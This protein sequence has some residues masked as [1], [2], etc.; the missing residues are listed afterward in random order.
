LTKDA[1]GEA[2][3]GPLRLQFDRFVKLAFRGSSISSDGGLLLH[4]ELDDAL[5][6]T[7]TAAGLIGDPRV[8]KNGRHRLTKL[9]RQSIFSR[10]AGYEGVNDA[11]RL[12]RDPLM[13]QLV[14]GRAVK[15]GAAS[16]SAM[17]RFETA[18]LTRPENLA[19]LA[20]LRGRWID[21][22]HDR[23]PPKV[24]TLDID[25]SESP[26]HGEQE[27][28]AWNGHFRSKCLHP[29]FVFNQFGDLE[30]CA[31]RPGNVHSADGWEAVLRPCWRATRPRP[32]PR[33]RGDAYAPTRLSPSRRRSTCRRPRA[34]TTPSGSRATRSCTR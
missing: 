10:L 8:G 22:V 34:G 33:S 6:L 2:Q 31:L 23:R 32:G 24:V 19:A 7:D 20:D 3:T 30:R 16:A 28:V 9:L 11:D 4:R 12:R 13:R 25:S 26:V 21:A 14:G 18:M 17:G 15:R 5:S 29:L 27:G 1:T